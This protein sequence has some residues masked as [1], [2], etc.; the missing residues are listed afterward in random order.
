MQALKQMGHD[1]AK[2][3]NDRL[4]AH[5]AEMKA[6]KATSHKVSSNPPFAVSDKDD[7]VDEDNA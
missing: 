6:P 3:F 2:T 4:I 5:M 7:E 1:P